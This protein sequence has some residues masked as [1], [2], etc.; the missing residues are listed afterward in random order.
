MNDIEKDILGILGAANASYAAGV[1]AG[2]DNNP[3][4]LKLCRL[5]AAIEKFLAQTNDLAWVNKCDCGNCVE[6]RAAIEEAKR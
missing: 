3:A 6:L 5:V 1:K 4:A 2:G